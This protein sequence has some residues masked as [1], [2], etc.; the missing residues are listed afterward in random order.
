LDSPLVHAAHQLFFPFA[1]GS[2]VV[3]YM[4][5]AGDVPHPYWYSAWVSRRYP[6]RWVNW[7]KLSEMANLP[8]TTR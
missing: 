1:E 3:E 4:R 8:L 6:H 7:L 2:T 5:Y